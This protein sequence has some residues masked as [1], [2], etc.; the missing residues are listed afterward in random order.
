[1]ASVTAA[2][3]AIQLAA[4]WLGFRTVEVG[5]HVERVGVTCFFFTVLYAFLAEPLTKALLP[6]QWETLSSRTRIDWRLQLAAMTQSLIIAPMATRIIVTRWQNKDPTSLME[7]LY[8]Y[9]E[10]E[11]NLGDIGLGYFV[12]DLVMM[13]RER[14]EYGWQMILH[15]MVPVCQLSR[16]YVSSSLFE[17]V[18][19]LDRR[20][21]AY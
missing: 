10:P 19:C 18:L 2:H 13:V 9:H 6:K 16:V 5:L 11:T 7:R 21:T 12:F 15:A 17:S 8:G 1:M 14:R 3:D 20:P 4:S